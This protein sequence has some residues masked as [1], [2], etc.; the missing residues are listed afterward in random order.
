MCDPTA[1]SSTISQHLRHTDD[2]PRAYSIKPDTGTLTTLPT[3][4]LFSA[5]KA[6]MQQLPRAQEH[7][8]IKNVSDTIRLVL[9]SAVFAV[10]LRES[11]SACVT[12]QTSKN[13]FRDQRRVSEHLLA[14][15]LRALLADLSKALF[16][17]A[18]SGK[19]FVVNL[20]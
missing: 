1:F 19:L 11:F 7:T 13:Q 15:H 12:L 2:Q 10:L 9:F 14:N 3:S 20:K 4:F 8:K 18:N 17:S 6:R 5:S 16:P